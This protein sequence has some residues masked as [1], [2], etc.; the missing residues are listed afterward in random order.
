[1]S[2]SLNKL[3]DF[4]SRRGQPGDAEKALGHYQRSLEVAE[5]LLAANPES[6][7]AARD[8]SVSLDMLGDFLSSRGQPGDAENALGHYQR[9]LELREG[10]LAANSESAQAARD[11][12]VSCWRMATMAE[13]TGVGDAMK[14][15]RKA[16]EILDEMKREGRFIT[17]QDEE[18]LE[19]LR[20]KVGR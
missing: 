17:P 8:V 9:S 1:V 7:Q 11:V 16:F 10:L 18:F 14:W 4:L 3:G 6:A 5:R 13:N 12:M 15:W 20:R 2:V 19:Q